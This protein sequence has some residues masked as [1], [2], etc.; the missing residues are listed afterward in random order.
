MSACGIW[1]RAASEPRRENEDP[2][3]F[4]RLADVP[5]LAPWRR[6]ATSVAILSDGTVRRYAVVRSPTRSRMIAA[7]RRR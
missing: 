7:S 1:I 3:D 4:R 5:D 2:A 6:E